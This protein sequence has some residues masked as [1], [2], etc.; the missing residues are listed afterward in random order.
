M[1]AEVRCFVGTGRRT[2][3]HIEGSIVDWF[4]VAVDVYLIGALLAAAKMAS[5]L[6]Y[7]AANEPERL[8]V[9]GRPGT[10]AQTRLAVSLAVG[11]A[12][13]LWPLGVVHGV[14]KWMRRREAS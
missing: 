9:D 5:E 4:W 14:A 3:H 13:L 1:T 8:E 12:G 11:L 6:G 2:S 7:I 10:E